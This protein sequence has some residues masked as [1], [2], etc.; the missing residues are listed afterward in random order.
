MDFSSITI[1][2]V[3]VGGFENAKVH[4]EINIVKSMPVLSVVQTVKGSYRF[5]LD[6]AGPVD[7]DERG[8]FVAPA[9]VTQH[10]NEFPGSEGIMTVHWVFFEV[11]L[12]NR[13]TLDELFSFPLLL[14]PSYNDEIFDL[15]EKARQEASLPGKLPCLARLVEILL[16]NARP[17]EK[18]SDLYLKLQNYI[19]ENFASGISEAGLCGILC[20]S[21]S[22]MYARFREL[23]GES[24]T[25]YLNNLRISRAQALLT[26]TDMPIAEI[27]AEVGIKDQFYFA[28]LF[29]NITGTSAG[30]YRRLTSKKA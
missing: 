20:C 18:R 12:D 7:T 21:R 28:R 19:E 22:A 3:K 5:A 14:P 25:R 4:P 2:K 1:G 23:M 15:I 13:R 24:P 11:T 26:S 16:E 9:N 17:V 27:A 10:I 29:K 6:N 8:V 30:A